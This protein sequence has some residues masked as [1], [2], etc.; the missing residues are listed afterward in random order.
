MS[1]ALESDGWRQRVLNSA[2]RSRATIEP[3]FVLPL[4]LPPMPEMPH[5]KWH[6][7]LGE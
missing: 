2:L 1:L 7:R 6:W 5:S 4:R 3:L